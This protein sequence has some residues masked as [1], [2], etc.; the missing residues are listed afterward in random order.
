MTRK[1]VQSVIKNIP[2]KKSLRSDRFTG[3]FYQTVNKK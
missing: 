3:E 1:P 2:M